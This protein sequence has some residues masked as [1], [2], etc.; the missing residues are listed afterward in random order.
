[1]TE[2]KRKIVEEADDL[3][4]SAM[5][6]IVG[7]NAGL[8]DIRLAERQL[9]DVLKLKASSKDLAEAHN[10][11]AQ[12]YGQTGRLD[13]VLVHFKAALKSTPHEAEKLTL[14]VASMLEKAKEWKTAVAVYYMGLCF[15]EKASLH[16]GLAYCF[17][18]MENQEA[19]EYHGRRACILKPGNVDY[20]NDLGYAFLEQGDL[21]TAKAYFE[22]ALKIDP[23]N[24]LARNNL[25]E[26]SEKKAERRP[27]SQKRGQKPPFC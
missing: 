18:K 8:G 22:N 23:K 4:Y 21:E 17:S 1:M 19:A 11:L 12:L 13:Q 6:E 2:N 24:E 10:L 5:A 26:C 25:T 27:K 14:N 9:L 15:T 7:S 3:P 20:V 16:H